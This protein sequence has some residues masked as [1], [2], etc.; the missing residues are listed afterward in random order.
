MKTGVGIWQESVAQIW[1][2]T[3]RLGGNNQALWSGD[4]EGPVTDESRRE[5]PPLRK[6]VHK[7][8]FTTQV[9]SAT[10]G[11][12]EAPTKAFDSTNWV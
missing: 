5:R 11:A 7:A 6:T 9:P 3:W 12:R 2:E 4:G 8:P 10:C 1:P